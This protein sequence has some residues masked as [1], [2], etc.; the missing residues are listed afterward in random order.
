MILECLRA[1]QCFHRAAA[2]RSAASQSEFLGFSKYEASE[3]NKQAASFTE[4]TKIL[5]NSE[6]SLE[7][8]VDNV[9]Q[10]V[11]CRQPP[12]DEK[13]LEP[14]LHP[15]NIFSPTISCTL[16]HRMLTH[17]TPGNVARQTIGQPTAQY[18]Q[19]SIHER[20]PAGLKENNSNTRRTQI[21]VWRGSK[22]HFIVWPPQ[23][24]RSSQSQETSYTVRPTPLDPSRCRPRTPLLCT[25]R[26]KPV[27]Q[28]PQVLA[29]TTPSHCGT[30][31]S[32]TIRGKVIV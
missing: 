28:A 3:R 27:E 2:V 14:T 21:S 18:Q 12:L 29:G 6:I 19:D 16:P 30:H 10:V 23:P 17:Y 25:F 9:T 24:S 1:L 22:V 32:H 15:S 5:K 13:L 20:A 7:N 11:A 26:T 31:N 8:S 4:S